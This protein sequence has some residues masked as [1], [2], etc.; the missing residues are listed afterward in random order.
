MQADEPVGQSCVLRTV[1]SCRCVRP[2]SGDD[3]EDGHADQC[4]P[5]RGGLV[6]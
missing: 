2:A 6:G 3:P 1:I 4:Y 5:R